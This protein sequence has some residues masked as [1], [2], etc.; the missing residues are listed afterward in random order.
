MSC[1]KKVVIVISLISTASAVT[2]PA[3]AQGL[4][5][6][7]PRQATIKLSTHGKGLDTTN[8]QKHLL[9]KGEISKAQV[10]FNL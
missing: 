1:L 2:M 7:K 9:L 6:E 10:R 8:D 3:F 4:S 5:W